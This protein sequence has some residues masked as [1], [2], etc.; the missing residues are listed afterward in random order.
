[1]Q[2]DTCELLDLALFLSAP[3]FFCLRSSER[4]GGSRIRVAVRSPANPATAQLSLSPPAHIVCDSCALCVA[5]TCSCL[6]ACMY[7][8]AC[9]SSVCDCGMWR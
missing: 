5:L 1:M 3:A 8:C 2:A 4:S 7:V 9:D 6:S